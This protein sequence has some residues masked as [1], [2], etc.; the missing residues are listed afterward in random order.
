MV[1]RSLGEAAEDDLVATFQIEDQPVRGRIARMGEHS[2]TPI[3]QRHDYPDGVARLLGEALALAA[4]VGSSLKFSGKLLVQAQGEGPIS[5]LVA[6]YRTDGGLRG[7]ARFDKEKWER[8][9]RINRGARAHM[10]Q[11][12]GSGVLALIM[13]RD[14]AESQPYQGIVAMERATLAECA[15]TYFSQSEQVPTRVALSVA[16]LR[17]PGAAASWRAGGL[18]VQQVAADDARGETED[19]WRTADALFSTL[20]DTE[21]VDPDLPADRLLYRLFH[22]DGVRL[23]AAS[24][25]RDECTCNETRLRE[26]LTTMPDAALRE[27]VEPDGALAA[28]CQFC[29]RIYRI[30]IDDVT[31]PTS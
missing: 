24:R 20:T 13:V 15:E 12:F 30:P 22:E 10:P 4:L 7:Y 11:V 17:A 23:E 9:D 25:L 21:L 8:L 28:D 31:G 3:I 27:M 2:L 14:G 1:S 6:E 16:E 19:A 26:T 29:S 5:L 18:M